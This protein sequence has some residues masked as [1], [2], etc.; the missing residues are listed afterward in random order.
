MKRVDH[1]HSECRAN[2]RSTVVVLAAGALIGALALAG[3][4]AGQVSQTAMQESAVN[5]SQAVINNVALRN[6]HIQAQQTSDYL[7]PGATVDLVLVVD[8]PVAGRHRQAG[9]HHQ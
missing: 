7:Q 2:H 8:Q 3:C 6:V 4:G 1:R 5:G 9:P